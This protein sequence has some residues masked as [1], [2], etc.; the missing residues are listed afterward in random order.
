[1]RIITDHILLFH[2]KFPEEVIPG[3][4]MTERERERERERELGIY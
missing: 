1:M 3:T 2:Q 4:L